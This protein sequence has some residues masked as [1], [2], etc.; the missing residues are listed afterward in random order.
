MKRMFC[1]MCREEIERN[2]VDD[3]LQLCLDEF[4]VEII[5]MKTDF[6]QREG[7]LC[8]VCLFRIINK[9]KEKIK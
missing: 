1:D 3:R 7:E 8:R 4:L 6:K 2:Y 9:G 5:A